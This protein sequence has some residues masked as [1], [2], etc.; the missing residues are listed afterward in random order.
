MT[1]DNCQPGAWNEEA[2]ISCDF[3]FQCPKTWE[4][5]SPTD[6]AGIRHCPECNRDVYLALTEEVFRQHASEGLCVAVRVLQANASEEEREEVYMVGNAD[7]APYNDDL[8]P[9]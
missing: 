6:N 3:S 1:D 8:K 4:Y 5:L 7:P 2:R 9:L